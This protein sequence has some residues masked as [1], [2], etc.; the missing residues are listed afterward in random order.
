MVDPICSFVFGGQAHFDEL[1]LDVVS[2]VSS[3]TGDGGGIVGIAKGEEDEEPSPAKAET[4]D[5]MGCEDSLRKSRDELVMRQKGEETDKD[6]D[7][8]IV[9]PV[10][11][12]LFVEKRGENGLDFF[13]ALEGV[14][15][16]R[17]L[18]PADAIPIR[19]SGRR[20]DRDRAR[21]LTCVV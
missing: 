19:Y 6:N 9:V 11:K 18:A 15:D 10:S 8:G 20:S 13:I 17:L 1:A 21:E 5:E 16:A 14:V 12:E 7:C 3:C 4:G 2:G